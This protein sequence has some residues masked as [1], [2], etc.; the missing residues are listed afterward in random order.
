METKTL[1]PEQKNLICRK[2]V[3]FT[4]HKKIAQ[5]TLVRY[6]ELELNEDELIGKIKYLAFHKGAAKWQEHIEV[7][8]NILNKDV[9]DRFAYTN[10]FARLRELVFVRTA[11]G[12]PLNSKYVVGTAG[13]W[14]FGR[15]KDIDN[16]HLSEYGYY[17]KSVYI[18]NGAMQ[19][20]R[21]GGRI[22]IES[23]ANGFNDFQRV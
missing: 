2:L 19:A 17:P 21:E 4:P 1:T 3:L 18:K 5:D 14:N 7:Y 22:A 16:L 6:P 10:L 20:L 11:D 13:C 8:R 12:K 9:L 15:G 23:T